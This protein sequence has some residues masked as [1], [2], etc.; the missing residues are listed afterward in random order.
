VALVSRI[1]GSGL[2]L[3]SKKTTNPSETHIDLVNNNND[4]STAS[5]TDESHASEEEDDEEVD[6]EMLHILEDSKRLK[7]LAVAFLHPEIPMKN[8]SMTVS[9]CYFDR[10]SSPV[11]KTIM[12]EVVDQEAEDNNEE[13]ESMEQE[14][15][16]YF[17]LHDL[18]K[19]KEL[20][21]QY[22]HPE[23]PV[24]CTDPTVFG[25]NYFDRPSAIPRESR[26]DSEERMSILA[27]AAEFR[28]LAEDYMHPE[29]PVRKPS[30]P[31]VFGRNYFDRPSA[32][33]RIDNASSES[34]PS[35]LLHCKTVHWSA[36]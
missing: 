9:R 18:K 15:E 22:A 29:K 14:E 26:D 20:A 13:N 24:R 30:D 31:T 23:L 33:H 36:L 8:T 19:L 2:L 25:R 21:I 17:L 4:D 3:P 12:E 5:L 1:S 6:K 7:A 28:Q 10:P 11:A 35:I 32:I 27:D 16:L 34:I